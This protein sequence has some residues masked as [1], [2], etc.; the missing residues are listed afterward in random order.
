MDFLEGE[1][2]IKISKLL[3]KNKNKYYSELFSSLQSSH[4]KVLFQPY[5]SVIESL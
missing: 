4:K 1:A 3:L 5:V 2:L